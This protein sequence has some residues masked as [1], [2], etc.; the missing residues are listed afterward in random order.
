MAAYRPTGVTLSMSLTTELAKPSSPI[1]QYLRF[2]S[3]L[4]A[5][6]GRGTPWAEPFKRLLGLDSLPGSTTVPLVP[7]ADAAMVGTAFDY[8]LRFHLAPCRGK[9]FVAWQGAGLLRR[10][11]PSTEGPL[12]RFFSNLDTLALKRS[13]AGQRLESDEE[14]LLCTYCVVLAQMEAV[15]RT[16]GAWFPHLRPAG[17]SKVRPEA[18]PLLQLASEAAVEDV[19]NLSRSA[20]EAMSPLIP[21][22]ANG[23][24]PYHPNPVFAG[25]SAIG[26]AD[27]DF[28]IAN[29]IFELKTTKTLN[30]AAVQNALL[31]LLG[32]SLLDYDD[33]YEIRRVGIYF[34]RHGWVRAWPLWELLFP[35]ADVIQRS[36]AGTE[37][38]EKEITARLDKLRRLM[39]RVVGGEAINYE[40]SFS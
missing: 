17:A 2:V 28:I 21:Y 22:V 9:D 35:L 13:P 1:T 26:G 14:R 5:D 16:R 19:V 39:Q 34:A 29:T 8:R 15:Y 3:A 7:G 18:E 10:L 25:S 24:L 27:A 31:Q 4:V 33:E 38:T 6:T 36:H 32:Y 12:A 37:P 23:S 11:D 40:E 30:T 20:S